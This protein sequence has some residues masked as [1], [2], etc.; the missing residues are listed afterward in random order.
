MNCKLKIN[1]FFFIVQL[2][3]NLECNYISI[4]STCKYNWLKN[5]NLWNTKTKFLQSQVKEKLLKKNQGNYVYQKHKMVFRQLI[6]DSN[7]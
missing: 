7:N 5:N 4:F 3:V 1:V 2:K 6:C